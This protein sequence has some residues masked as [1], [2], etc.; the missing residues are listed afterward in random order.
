MPITPSH[1]GGCKW[2]GIHVTCYYIDTVFGQNLKKQQTLREWLKSS[3]EM[4]P[5]GI[6]EYHFLQFQTQHPIPAPRAL[7]PGETPYLRWSIQAHNAVRARQNKSLADEDTVVAAYKSGKM[8][9]LD[10][11]VQSPESRA[12]LAK[13]GGDPVDDETLEKQ[14]TPYVLA[15]YI[16]GTIVG[17]ILI[18][19]FLWLAW[20]LVHQRSIQSIP[21]L[22]E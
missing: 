16:L 2:L 18:A 12:S 7:E 17:L 1:W 13:L 6:C 8:Y 4:L 3:A 11:Y 10:S 20:Y 21:E 14:F 15:T 9:G 19:G 22:S 5:C